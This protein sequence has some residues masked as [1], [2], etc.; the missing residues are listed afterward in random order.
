MGEPNPLGSLATF[1]DAGGGLT[2]LDRVDQLAQ[3]AFVEAI[4]ATPA[5]RAE[6]A[7]EYLELSIEVES[8]T[9]DWLPAKHAGER[10][11]IARCL[12][13]QSEI[14]SDDRLGARVRDALPPECA[15]RWRRELESLRHA[16]PL[17]VGD[18]ATAGSWQCQ[19]CGA[20]ADA[21][22]AEGL[23]VRATAE[24]ELEVDLAFCAPCVSI[25]HAVL[26]GAPTTP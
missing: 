6:Q 2:S 10:D 4:L 12:R 18:P 22:A 17:D 11:A 13:W 5:A 9:A 3:V 15:Q 1:L 23:I 25:A 21:G 20:T 8:G 16:Y 19:N 24:N 7:R 26:Q 14:L